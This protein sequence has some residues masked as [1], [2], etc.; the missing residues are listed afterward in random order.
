MLVM[1]MLPIHVVK[2]PG[3]WMTNGSINPLIRT[4][5][6]VR[7]YGEQ[8]T[9]ISRIAAI[10]AGIKTSWPWNPTEAEAKATFEAYRNRKSE[11]G[12]QRGD[13]ILP[14]IH[15][16]AQ[17]LA[18][19]GNTACLAQCQD[20]RDLCECLKLTGSY[21]GF[22]DDK[23]I[24]AFVEFNRARFYGNDNCNTGRD[25]YEYHFGWE[26]S[27]VVYIEYR[28]YGG[29]MNVLTP[30]WRGY[31]KMD[32]DRFKAHCQELAIQTNADESDCV[33][34]VPS[35]RAGSSCKWRLWWD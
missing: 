10:N 9:E 16:T 33:E 34:D 15:T 21:N 31:Y 32:S 13:G 25:A 24:A 17:L 26:G 11:P 1:D 5:E 30:G 28:A 35:S 8:W 14:G 6:E 19:H 3:H 22:D 2:L 23:S 20:I 12:W 7:H 29:E 4:W 18:K 27:H